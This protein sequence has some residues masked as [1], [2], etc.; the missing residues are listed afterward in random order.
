MGKVIN[1]LNNQKRRKAPP[2]GI[3]TFNYYNLFPITRLNGLTFPLSI[4]T[5]NY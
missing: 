2:F 3:N 1:T 4:N 5:S